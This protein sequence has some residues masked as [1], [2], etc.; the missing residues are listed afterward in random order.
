MLVGR[1]PTDLSRPC[2]SQ[3]SQALFK[4]IEAT[5]VKAEI[6][7]TQDRYLADQT[8]NQEVPSTRAT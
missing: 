1:W 3:L 7:G 2:P 5:Q 6:E 4:E 8:C